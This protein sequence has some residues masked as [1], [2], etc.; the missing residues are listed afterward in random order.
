MPERDLRAS[1]DFWFLSILNASSRLS[2]SIYRDLNPSLC[3]LCESPLSQ[4]CI[5]NARSDLPTLSKCNQHRGTHTTC[6]YSFVR[7][8]V[9]SRPRL[10]LSSASLSGN[11]GHGASRGRRGR[12]AQRA[13]QRREQRRVAKGLTGNRWQIKVA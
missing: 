12:P 5:I 6:S 4:A 8:V 9:R 13:A 7:R 1:Q 11:Q 3:F 10:L 2:C